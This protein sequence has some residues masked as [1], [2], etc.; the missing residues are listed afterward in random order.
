MMP[1]VLY[2]DYRAQLVQNINT[3][4]QQFMA[5][6]TPLV[7]KLTTAIQHQ[8]YRDFIRYLGELINFTTQLAVTAQTLSQTPGG[9]AAVPLV[10][11]LLDQ[12]NELFRYV[13]ADDDPA[14][15]K[16]S[17]ITQERAYARALVLAQ[18]TGEI[19]QPIYNAYGPWANGS[20]TP[21][22]AA[23]AG[24]LVTAVTTLT[25]QLQARSATLDTAFPLT[26]PY[27]HTDAQADL[28][29]LQNR[30]KSLLGQYN[31]QTFRTLY[32]VGPKPTDY[33]DLCLDCRR[34][35]AD[36]V[37]RGDWLDE[38]PLNEEMAYTPW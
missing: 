37:R 1:D 9:P 17:G 8:R 20:P 6:Y 3:V 25:T 10:T 24:P 32:W 30:M 19:I 11:K 33:R 27:T 36:V 4:H 12:W 28:H 18:L 29:A 14:A 21:D 34:Q 23:L 15:F 16:D 22:P 31:D 13:P 7:N 5:E 26:R 2:T 38:Q 35:I